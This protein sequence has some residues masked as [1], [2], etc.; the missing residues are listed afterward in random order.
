MKI[1]PLVQAD[2]A[3]VLDVLEDVTVYGIDQNDVVGDD[4]FRSE[5]GVPPR[6]RRRRVDH[7]HDSGFHQSIGGPAIDVDFVEDHDVSRT[8]A[9]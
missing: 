7:G 1:S 8:D 2:L 3:A 6:N 5:V 4:H 9:A